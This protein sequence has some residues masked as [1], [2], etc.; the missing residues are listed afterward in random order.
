MQQQPYEQA[1]ERTLFRNAILMQ[2]ASRFTGV[3]TGSPADVKEKE[4]DI[5]DELEAAETDEDEDAGLL[6]CAF[7]DPASRLQRDML[8]AALAREQQ[9]IGQLRQKFSGWS[10]GGNRILRPGKYDDRAL[11]PSQMTMKLWGLGDVPVPALRLN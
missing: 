5:D 6:A 9:L 7:N 4:D 1:I 3:S 8:V 10:N 11:R 2:M